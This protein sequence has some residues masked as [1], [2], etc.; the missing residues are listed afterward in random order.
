MNFGEAIE[1]AKSGQRIQR[2]GW[3]GRGMFVYMERGSI[4]QRNLP[5]VADDV[6]GVPLRLFDFGGNGD[7][8][9]NPCLVMISAA[10]VEVP[11]WLASQTDMVAEDWRV[12][13]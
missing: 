3:N 5:K 11:G 12:V 10:G 6:G 1:A 4:A 13:E 2:A 7:R 8:T 9:R